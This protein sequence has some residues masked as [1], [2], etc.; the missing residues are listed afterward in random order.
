[1]SFADDLVLDTKT[2]SLVSK[3][4]STDGKSLRSIRRDATRPLATPC[5]ITIAHEE[6][7]TGTLVQSMITYEDTEYGPDGIAIGTL[8]YM[9]KVSR[10]PLIHTTAQVESA[11]DAVLAFMTEP[12]QVKMNNKEI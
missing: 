8:K 10:N 11:R 12:N 4:S 3:S 2:Y 1:M 7:K 5:G 9:I 6:N